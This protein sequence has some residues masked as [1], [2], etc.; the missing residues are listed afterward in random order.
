MFLPTLHPFELA[1]VSLNCTGMSSPS[2]ILSD[3]T[4]TR[5]AEKLNRIIDIPI[6]GEHHEL[7]LAE[8]LIDMCLG[9][10][11]EDEEDF[12]E[13]KREIKWKLV[14]KLNKVLNVPF[15][16]EKQEE[17]ILSKIV[18]FVLKD[19]FTQDAE[20]DDDEAAAEE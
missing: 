2:L 8:K 14:R 6:L 3:D 5:L 10:F 11:G 20:K 19:T 7:F 15:A 4:R 17:R 9:A 16:N 1:S 18:D 13:M 12:I